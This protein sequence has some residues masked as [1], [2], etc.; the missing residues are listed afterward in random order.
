M[1]FV[2]WFTFV[3][4]VGCICNLLL[5]FVYFCENT[6]FVFLYLVD[7]AMYYIC[8]HILLGFTLFIWVADRWRR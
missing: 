2:L 3:C 8:K 6:L 1:L 7:L 5:V 4:W